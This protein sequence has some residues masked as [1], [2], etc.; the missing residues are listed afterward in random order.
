VAAPEF[1]PTDPTQRTRTYSS[2][3]SRKRSWSAD[4][5]GDVRGGQPT[6]ARLGAQ[7]PDQGY[8]YKLVG[9]FDDRLELGNVHKADAVAA[10]VAVG[11]KRAAL[12]G[13]A[14]VVHDLTV[15]FTVF[16]FLD[17]DAPADLVEWREA[18]FPEIHHE[19]HY[20]ERR[21]IVD[22]VSD[23]VLRRPH[24]AIERDYAADWRQNV[25]V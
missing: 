25:A 22:L 14:P 2:P 21:D 1:V 9:S 20:A 23:E 11:M 12:Y 6:G 24:A 4:R 13:R 17:A 16:G 5:P 8:A 3:P 15:G 18:E 10:A 7:G 19:H